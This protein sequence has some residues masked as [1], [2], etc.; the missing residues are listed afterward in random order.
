MLVMEEAL[1]LNARIELCA[2]IVH[3]KREYVINS[4]EFIQVAQVAVE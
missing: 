3:Q 1:F 4:E 2:G